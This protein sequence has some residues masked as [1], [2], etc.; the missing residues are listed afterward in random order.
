MGRPKAELLVDGVRLLD[1][2]VATVREAGCDPVFA[3][4]PDGTHV[5]GAT[6]VVNPAPERG[7]RSSL[8]L[9]V[10]AAAA[11][12]ALAVV[13]VDMPGVGVD[14]IRAVTRRWQPGRI[15]VASYPQRPRAHPVVMAPALWREALALAGP[16]EGARALMKR[17]ADLVD[18][19]E[20]AGDADDLD[21]PEDVRRWAARPLSRSRGNPA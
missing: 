21:T 6:A 5:Q 4:V 13:L 7:M 14:A 10:Q 16:D 12:D 19:V 20:V 9:A 18:E 17:R 1:R 2:A 11:C 3:V 15:A 8:E